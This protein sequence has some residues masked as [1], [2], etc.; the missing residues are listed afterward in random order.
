M[1]LR[2]NTK[3]IVSNAASIADI[4]VALLVSDQEI[5]QAKEHFWV[6]GLNSQNYIQYI[7][8]V[9]LGILTSTTIHPREVFRLAVWK[10]V[11]AIV[12]AHNHTSVNAQPSQA[13]INTTR[14]LKEA[15][16]ILGIP[17]LDHV[18]VAQDGSFYS[19]QQE[20]EIEG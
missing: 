20:R 14:S 8:L 1:I 5:D 19:F 17:V 7:D 18:I 4:C 10:G 13:D 12:I 6:F 3:E 2:E 9:T 16:N 11:N 15:G